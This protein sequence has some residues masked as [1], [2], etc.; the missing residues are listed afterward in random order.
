MSKQVFVTGPDGKE[1][2]CGSV[3]DGNHGALVAKAVREHI[4]AVAPDK[5]ADHS[6][7]VTVRAFT[8]DEIQKKIDVQNA[9]I[10]AK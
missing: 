2:H 4:D 10:K 3:D 8:P 5:L 9:E 1:C 7:K 6:F